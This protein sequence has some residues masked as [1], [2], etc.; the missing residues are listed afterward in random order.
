MQHG[1]LGWMYGC[2]TYTHLHGGMEN[3]APSQARRKRAAVSFLKSQALAGLS[4]AARPA[5]EENQTRQ[6]EA[7]TSDLGATQ[8][9]IAVAR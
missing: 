8:V 5:R 2:T 6:A 7:Q 3:L 1:M 4:Q 9:E